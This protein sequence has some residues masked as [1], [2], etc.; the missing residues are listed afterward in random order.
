MNDMFANV[1]IFLSLVAY[2]Y[3][4]NAFTARRAFV[5]TTYMLILFRHSMFFWSHAIQLT[6]E[7]L[8]SVGRIQEFLLLPESKADAEL[9]AQ[10]KSLKGKGSSKEEETLMATTNRKRSVNPAVSEWGSDIAFFK[11]RIVQTRLEKNQ[12]PRLAFRKATAAWMR[13]NNTGSDVGIVNVDLE[14]EAGKLC[15]VVGSVGS[16]KSSLLQVVLGELDLDE[17]SALVAG[18]VSYAAQEPWLFEGSVRQNIIFVEP[19]N[20]E[21]FD[22]I[23]SSF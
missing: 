2:V 6:A 10:R 14:V 20:E 21:R 23:T 13:E 3:Y 11:R 1:A 18:V 9:L 17:G 19:W 16:G 15:A 4:G 8:V 22:N 5:V 7:A 12:S